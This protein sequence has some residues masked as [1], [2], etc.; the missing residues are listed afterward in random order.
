MLLL[1][2]FVVV[3]ALTADILNI[4]TGQGFGYYQL[5]VL[6]IG[7]VL[8]LMGAALLLRRWLNSQSDDHFE[9]EP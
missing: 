7:I 6:I 1:G 5:I 4:G 2:I 8:T 9:P 3:L